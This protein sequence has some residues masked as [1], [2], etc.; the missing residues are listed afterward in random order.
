MWQERNA[1]YLVA[2]AIYMEKRLAEAY[3]GSGPEERAAL[4]E[5]LTA[6]SRANGEAAVRNFF[7]KNHDENACSR[8]LGFIAD[9]IF[10]VTPKIP[11]YDELEELAAWAQQQ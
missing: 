7:E 6:E 5:K 1:S 8:A 9:G 4:Y 2:A 11:V 3:A 10:D